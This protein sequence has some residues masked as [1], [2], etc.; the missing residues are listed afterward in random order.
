M[1]SGSRTQPRSADMRSMA[2]LIG[3]VRR[4]EGRE[5][6]R[7]AR[8]N[9]GGSVRSSL[10]VGAFDSEGAAT[11]SGERVPFRSYRRCGDRAPFV[12]RKKKNPG[13]SLQP[14]F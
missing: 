13:A 11:L 7:Q 3:G 9:G 10:R 6:E 1:R 4:R 14:G 12:F 2:A 5:G 8:M